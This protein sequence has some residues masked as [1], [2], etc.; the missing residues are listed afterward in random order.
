MG[1]FITG[2]DGMS[3]FSASSF[4][5]QTWSWNDAWMELFA[6]RAVFS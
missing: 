5:L 6:M 1:F 2:I 4:F 3:Q